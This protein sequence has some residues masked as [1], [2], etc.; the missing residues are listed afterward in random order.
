MIVYQHFNKLIYFFTFL[1]K[2]KTTIAMAFIL[3]ANDKESLPENVLCSVELTNQ[4]F[5]GSTRFVQ[6]ADEASC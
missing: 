6:S 4:D 3:E 2:F 5:G 1:K